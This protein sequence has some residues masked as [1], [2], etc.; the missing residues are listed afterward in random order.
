[1]RRSA[2]WAIPIGVAVLVL[3]YAGISYVIAAGVSG[4]ERKP[5][6][7]RPEAHGLAY[8]DVAFSSRKGDVTL[9][10]WYMTPRD[11]APTLIFVHGITGNRTSDKAVDLAAR[12]G[13]EGYNVLMFDLRG[14]GESGGKRISGGYFERQ[15]VLGAFDFLVARGVSPERIG[16][17]GFSMGAG[18]AILAAAE[19][20][21]IWALVADSP[22]AHISD[23]LAFEV[24]RKTVL[25]RWLVP[26]FVPGA[27][28]WADVLYGIKIGELV[29][30]DA[31]ARIGYP[32]L[33]IHGTA[34][35]RIPYEHGVRVHRA[36]RPGSE[37][38]LVP[39]VDHVDAFTTYPE[40]YVR[41]VE[42]YFGERLGE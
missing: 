25:P 34:D 5:L 21:G 42:A 35:T 17:V 26:A 2:K 33:V 27:K 16:V 37:L 15:D 6:E 12:L 41:R 13:M 10:G 3:M 31:A 9:R 22:Y 19:E 4:A 38:W 11:G 36:S 24:A 39:D 8:E 32:I 14:H 29:P 20:Q 7:D 23:L 28:L 1:M 30:E 18:T 40:E